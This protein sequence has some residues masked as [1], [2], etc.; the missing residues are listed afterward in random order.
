MDL[1]ILIFKCDILDALRLDKQEGVLQRTA[2]GVT[3][4]QQQFEPPMTWM[5]KSGKTRLNKRA[6]FEYS[7]VKEAV[8]KQ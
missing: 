8:Q 7:P 1:R 2:H 6:S 3:R 4:A 5:F